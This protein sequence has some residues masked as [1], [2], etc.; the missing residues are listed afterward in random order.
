MSKTKTVYEV[1]IVLEYEQT[2]FGGLCKALAQIQDEFGERILNID[3]SKETIYDH[4]KEDG[5]TMSKYYNL[6]LKNNCFN[7]GNA[8]HTDEGIDCLLHGWYFKK[9]IAIKSTC[10]KWIKKDEEP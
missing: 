9:Y 6:P 7:C 4:T 1:T 3:I 2:E 5:G 10:D 8:E